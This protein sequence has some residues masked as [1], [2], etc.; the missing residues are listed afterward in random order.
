MTEIFLASLRVRYY[1]IILPFISSGFPTPTPLTIWILILHKVN[2]NSL[3]N[4]CFISLPNK[5][6]ALW[7]S[8]KLSLSWGL[9]LLVATVKSRLPQ[10]VKKSTEINCK[11]PA[12]GLHAW[13][14]QNV[15]MIS[16]N[17]TMNTLKAQTRCFCIYRFSF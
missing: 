1:S 17:S 10:K 2:Q 6:A 11:M 15:T 12:A 13:W 7:V 3:R 14:C 8:S 16:K 9:R 4:S 5:P